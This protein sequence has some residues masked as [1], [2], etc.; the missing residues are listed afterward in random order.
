MIRH[1]HPPSEGIT[2][3]S[4]KRSNRYAAKLPESAIQKL[5]SDSSITTESCFIAKS[6]SRAKSSSTRIGLWRPSIRYSIATNVLKK[7]PGRFSREDLELLIWSGYTHEEQKV[8]RDGT[9]RQPCP[10][11]G[12]CLPASRAVH[13]YWRGFPRR[14][15]I[16]Q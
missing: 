3:L 14:L 10:P 1:C 12:S 8:F 11:L 9:P 16:V 13:Q 2:S 5:Y 4:D 7:L 6:Y 15:E